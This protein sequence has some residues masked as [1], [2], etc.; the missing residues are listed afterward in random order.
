MSFYLRVV[1][2]GV[3]LLSISQGAWAQGNPGGP[4]QCFPPPCV[5]ITDHIGWLIAAMV[6]FGAFKTWQYMRKPALKA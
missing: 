3:L 2:L 6:G 1:G 4:G 5:P